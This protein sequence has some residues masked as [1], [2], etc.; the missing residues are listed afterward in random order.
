MMRVGRVRRLP[1][2]TKQRTLVGVIS[3]D[4]VLLRAEEAG[5]VKETGVSSDDVV[6]ALRAINT[7]QLPVVAVKQATA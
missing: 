7:H 5:K 2:I 4:D 1:V 6:K 3:M